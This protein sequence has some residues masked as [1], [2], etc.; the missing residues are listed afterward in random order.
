MKFALRAAIIGVGSLT[1]VGLVGLMAWGLLNQTPVTALSG[2]TRIGKPPPDFTVPLF[3]GEELALSDSLGRPMVI[4]FWASWCW[5]CRVEARGLEQTWRAYKDQ[6]VLFI[7]LDVGW[8]QGFQDPEDSAR[9]YLQEFDVTYPNG[10]DVDGTI[11]VDYGIVG[12][13]VTFFVSREGI[14]E[15]RWLGAIPEERLI[16]WLDELVAGGPPSGEVEGVNQEAFF[17]TGQE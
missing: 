10:R 17:Q 3:E 9:A 14:V 12:I 11:T 2:L 5:P 16:V 8:L 15:R 13:P 7:G 6:D 1:I 4:N